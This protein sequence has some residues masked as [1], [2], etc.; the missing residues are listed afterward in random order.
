MAF[1]IDFNEK[2]QLKLH[3]RK[4]LLYPPYWTDINNQ[5]NYNLNWKSVKFNRRNLKRLPNQKGIYCFVVIP[6]YPNFFQSKYLFYIGQT[7]RTLKERFKEY[8][9]DQGGNG[10]PRPKIYEMLSLYRDHLYFYYSTILSNSQIDEVEEKLL[11]T[12]VP[13]INTDIPIAKIKN[14]IKNIY[15]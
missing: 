1:D 5:F 6:D 15:E 11:N 12:F 14:E 13:H 10:K 7:T 8:L 4:F 9:D 3:I 2:G